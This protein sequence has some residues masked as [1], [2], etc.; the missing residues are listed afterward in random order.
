MR[1]ARPRGQAAAIQRTLGQNVH[2]LREGAGMSQEEL[3]ARSDVSRG[4]IS[5]I[6][7]GRVNV[8]LSTLVR[9]ARVLS[10]SAVDLLT[11]QSC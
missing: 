8:T 9:L 10:V 1:K 11:V 6:E 2:A 5:R 7:K 3:A 4:Y